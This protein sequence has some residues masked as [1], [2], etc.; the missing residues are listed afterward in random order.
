MPAGEKHA[1]QIGP[2]VE[3]LRVGRILRVKQAPPTGAYGL[4]K[5]PPTRQTM[6]RTSRQGTGG[7]P[8]PVVLFSA[9]EAASELPG[10]TIR[11]AE[12][13]RRSVSGDR[14]RID[15]VVCAVRPTD[16]TWS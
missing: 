15:A 8:D 11:R 16:P 12:A 4:S 3:A 6:N 7:P 5:R 13:V 2:Q 9:A 1:Q 10:L 14:R